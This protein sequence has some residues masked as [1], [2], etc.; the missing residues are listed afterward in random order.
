MT[1]FTTLFANKGSR[2]ADAVKLLLDSDNVGRDIVELSSLAK[3][4][5][6]EQASLAT[7]IVVASWIQDNKIDTVL[8]DLDFSKIP[9]SELQAAKIKHLVQRAEVLKKHGAWIKRMLAA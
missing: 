9:D 6:V 4:Q 3:L 5:N 8:D 2:M 1:K 7:V